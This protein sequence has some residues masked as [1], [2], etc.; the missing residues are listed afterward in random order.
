MALARAIKVLALDYGAARTGVAVADTQ[1]RLALARPAFLGGDFWAELLTT[2]KAENIGQIVVGL[3]QGL[4]GSETAQTVRTRQFA[5]ELARRS[6][7]PVA[8]FDE[9][10]TSRVAAQ[11]LRGAT[12]KI[13][14]EKSLADSEAARVLLQNWLD[15]GRGL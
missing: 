5:A 8:L 1:L 14:G 6:A 10:L 13:R 2:L 15:C 9:R 11:N 12:K 7:L 4:T 3:P